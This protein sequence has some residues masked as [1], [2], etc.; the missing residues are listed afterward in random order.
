MVNDEAGLQWCDLVKD[1]YEKLDLHWFGLWLS[2]VTAGP[3]N[4]RLAAGN[5][6]LEFFSTKKKKHDHKMF[7]HAARTRQRR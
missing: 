6:L 7:I 4:Y 2:S 3:E 1:A 5:E